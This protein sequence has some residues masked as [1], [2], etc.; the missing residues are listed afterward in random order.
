M[1]VV[2]GWTDCWTS[3]YKQVKFTEERKRALVDRIRKRRYNFTYDV[4][5]N[6]PYCAPFYEDG[7]VCV[8]TRSEWD[9]VM[10]SAYGDMPRGSRLTP[11][12][13]ISDPPKNSVLYEKRKFLEEGDDS[14]G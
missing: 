12:D 9:D 1:N 8:L 2:V 13:V 10:A 5:Q 4:H 11:M 7:V 6:V 3:P 14:N